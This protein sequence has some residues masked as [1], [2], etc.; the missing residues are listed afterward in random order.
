MCALDPSVHIVFGCGG[1]SLAVAVPSLGPGFMCRVTYSN[2]G[3]LS[4]VNFLLS[5]EFYTKIIAAY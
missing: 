4:E 2:M 5:E 1:S 3:S